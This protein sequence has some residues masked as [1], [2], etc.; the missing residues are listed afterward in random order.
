MLPIIILPQ[1]DEDSDLFFL[2]IA[3]DNPAVAYR[4][5]E[6]IEDTHKL[7]ASSPKL[8]PIFDTSNPKLSGMRWFPVK[9]F[10]KHLIFYIESETQITIVRVLHKA[11][12]ISKI[13]T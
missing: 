12:N 10:P 7:I 6:R 3:K 8:A 9:N 2:Y 5:L 1:A 11:Q 4:F 13:L